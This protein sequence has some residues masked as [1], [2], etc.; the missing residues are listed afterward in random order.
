[1]TKAN[2]ILT[3]F[4]QFLTAYP[5]EAV[6]T[7]AAYPYITIENVADSFDEPVEVTAQLYFRTESEAIPNAKVAEISKAIGRGGIVI[8]YDD[9]AIWVTKS[10]PFSQGLSEEDK[11]NKRRILNLA[12]EFISN[13]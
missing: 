12:F 10:T 13:Y 9:G 1:M 7:D 3:Y 4:G 6:P 5:A 2:A 11:A 8:P